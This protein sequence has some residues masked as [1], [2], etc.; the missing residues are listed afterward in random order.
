MALVKIGDKFQTT[1]FGEVVVSEVKDSRNITVVFSDGNTVVCSAGNLRRGLIRNDYLPSVLGV[2]YIGRGDF[3]SR[4]VGGNGRSVAYSTW[5]GMIRR[6]YCPKSLVKYPTYVGCS[7]DESWLNYQ[8]FAKWYTSQKSYGLG[9]DLDKDL[10]VPSNKVYSPEFCSLIPHEV[11]TVLISCS[12]SRGMWPRGVGHD[13]RD[14]TFNAQITRQCVSEHLGTFATQEQAFV[15]Y[16]IAK[17]SYVKEVAARHRGNLTDAVYSNLM[18]YTVSI[19][20]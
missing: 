18:A 5:S 12:S 3:S 11:N 19:T 8:N 4:I 1:K 9:F 16:K 17:E 2:G 20:D 7:V 14:G 6:C 15:A 13:K 10:T